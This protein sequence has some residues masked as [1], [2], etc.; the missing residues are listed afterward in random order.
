MHPKEIGDILKEAR[1]KKNLS[2]E[3]IYKDTRIQR[4]IVN[5][6]E[7][8][9]AER[10][11]AGTYIVLFLKKYASYLNLDAEALAIDYK[12]TLK[13][14]K[15]QKLEP[16]REAARRETENRE[17]LFRRVI[18]FISVL[19]VL[20]FL[21]L[22]V[23]FLVSA[24][25]RVKK[26]LPRKKVTQTLP[27]QKGENISLELYAKQDVW[28]EIIQ[29]GKRVFRGTLRKGETKIL[30]ASKNFSLW[31]GKTEVVELTVNGKKIAPLAKGVQKNIS[32]TRD[33]IKLP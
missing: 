10:V 5:A 16:E 2:F 28:M 21:F 8:G 3:K 27:V 32:I 18:F 33:G 19:L 26:N 11:L 9:T 22:T 25:K 4:H 24:A 1:S 15:E 23:Q 29:D 6:L 7:D 17:N 14:E 12:T 30:K 13:K 31:L 20:L